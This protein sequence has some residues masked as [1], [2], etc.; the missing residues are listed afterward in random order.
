MAIGD[1]IG[2]LRS[3]FNDNFGSTYKRTMLRFKSTFVFRSF[4]VKRAYG[5][6]G[7]SVRECG[8][9]IIPSKHTRS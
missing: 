6:I 5:E 8:L 4:D 7:D 1:K 3:T 2:S 9:P